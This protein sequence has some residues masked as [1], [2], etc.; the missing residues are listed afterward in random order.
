MPEEADAIDGL[1]QT[2]RA[3]SN[4]DL[5]KVSWLNRILQGPDPLREKLTLFWHGH[6]AT[7]DKKVSRSP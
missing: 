1:R 3:S 6:F 7:S 5:L 4:L 2:A